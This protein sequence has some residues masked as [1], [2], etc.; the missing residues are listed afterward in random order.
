MTSTHRN[1]CCALKVFVAG[2]WCQELHIS[3]IT[4][5][6]GVRMC[7][8]SQ[9]FIFCSVNV[10]LSQRRSSSRCSRVLRNCTMTFFN[11]ATSSSLSIHESTLSTSYCAGFIRICCCICYSDFL[12]YYLETIANIRI[13][14]ELH[15]LFRKKMQ[16]CS[17]AAL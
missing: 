12:V 17:F 10:P 13:I 15:K 3:S 8:D 5:L 14:S 2:N 4:Y 16:K 11:S 9:A 6:Y 1:S 7:S